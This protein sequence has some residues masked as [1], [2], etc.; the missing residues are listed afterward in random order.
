MGPFSLPDAPLRLPEDLLDSYC[1]DEDQPWP[2]PP[3]GPLEDLDALPRLQNTYAAVVTFVDAQLGVLL[4]GLREQ[5][6]LDDLLVCITAPH[7]LRLGE[8]GVV[9]NGDAQ[10]YEEFVH[11]PLLLRLPNAEAAGLRLDA[12]TQPVDLFPTLLAGQ[13]IVS[14]P[15]HGHDLWPLIRG[16]VDHVRE[17]ACSF[18]GEAGAIRS[19]D[20]A[21]VLPLGS[22]AKTAGQERLFVKP[23]DRW[24]VNNVRQQHLDRAEEMAK[25]LRDTL[26]A[27]TDSGGVEGG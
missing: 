18:T 24:E 6:L 13:G 11:V 14:P 17:Q 12:L 15:S 10:P 8:H 20:W 3:L 25:A 22:A 4:A 26:T 5:K 23:D 21:L 7:G 1:E 2:D 16:E 19:E 27:L 9:G